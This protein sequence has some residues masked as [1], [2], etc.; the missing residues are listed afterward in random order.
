[1]KLVLAT[2]NAHKIVEMKKVFEELPIEILSKSDIGCGEIEVDET[3]DTLEGNAQLK[4]SAIAEKTDF[5]VLADDTGL[6]VEEL[7]GEPGVHSA[8]YAGEHDDE[9]N[10]QKLLSA[11][12]DKDNRS[13][14]FKT[15]LIL[16]E[17]DKT[18]VS[19]DGIC[20]GT[21]TKEKFGDDSFGYDC[22]FMPEGYE[23][24]FGQMTLEEKNQ[25]SHRAKALQRLKTYLQEKL[26]I[27]K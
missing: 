14:Y 11:L 25:I 15:Q 10:R 23:K 1:M 22:I 5:Y 12:K 20:E 3:K 26:V 6:F 7:G 19:L 9:A 21:I 4:A 16:I 24:T 27:E 8:R 17:P 2:D 18:V 13:A